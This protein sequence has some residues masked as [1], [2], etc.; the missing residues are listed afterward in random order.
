MVELIAALAV[1][2]AMARYGFIEDQRIKAESRSWDAY[3]I[4]LT[5]DY[6]LAGIGL[7]GGIGLW[8]EMARRRAPGVW[9]FGRWSWSIVAVTI[10]LSDLFA[11]AK[12]L[13]LNHVRFGH[14]LPEIA[15]IR[16]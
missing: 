11:L 10:I 7:A 14:G 3:T 9:G 1:G 12:D 2:M 13:F 6:G 8:I 16:S 15:E 4:E 5:L